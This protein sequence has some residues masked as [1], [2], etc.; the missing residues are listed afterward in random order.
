MTTLY[1]FNKD[2]LLFEKT[3]KLLKYK[4]I[5]STLVI[6]ILFLCSFSAEKIIKEK[7][8]YTTINNKDKKIKQ[9]ITP[10]RE[11]TYV[12]DLY[13]TI[14]FNLSEEDYSRFS[15]LSIKYRDEIEKAK[16]PASLVWW[17]AYKESGFD[18]NEK[19][20]KSS[21][22]GMFQFLDGT[23]NACCKMAGETVQGRYNEDKQI[24]IMLVYLNY[25]YN[26]HKDWKKS[27]SEYHGGKYHYPVNFLL[28]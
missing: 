1:K 5:T 28:K 6:I 20:L 17:I 13:K 22:K 9:I 27:V 19:N 23:W 15:E 26:K 25:L 14:G 24:R 11:E 2:S 3:N 7:H 18:I 21:A 12:E 4:I 8:L 16:I 10:I